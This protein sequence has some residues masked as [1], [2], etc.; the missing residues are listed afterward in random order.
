MVFTFSM[1]ISKNILGDSGAQTLGF[2]TWI[3]RY[4]VFDPNTGNQS[5]TWFVPILF[6]YVPLFDLILVIVSRIRR[7]KKYI[8]SI[9]DH[10]FHRLSQV[11]L[12]VQEAVL[13]MHGASLTMSMAG[14][15]CLNLD[16][17]YANFIFLLILIFTVLG[18]IKLDRNYY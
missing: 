3:Y 15:L 9:M 6:F 5:S 4:I 11:G 17:I 14:Y 18:L 10:T 1:H 16:F 13:L 7:K 2:C 8:S 12:P